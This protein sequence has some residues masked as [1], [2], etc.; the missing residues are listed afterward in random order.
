MGHAQETHACCSLFLQGKVRSQFDIY[1]RVCGAALLV[2]AP[3]QHH[4][5]VRTVRRGIATS[6]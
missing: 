3:T 6:E 1:T 5:E 2:G 4:D